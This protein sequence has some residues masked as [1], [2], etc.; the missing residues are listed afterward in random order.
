MEGKK[1]SS[2]SQFGAVWFRFRKNKLAL[3]GLVLLVIIIFLAI[4]ANLFIDEELVKAMS[5]ANAFQPP[6]AEHWFGTDNY[7]RDVFARVIYG[8]RV[9]LRV[10]IIAVF[11]AVTI[12]GLLGAA[13]GYFGGV[14]ENVIMR[15]MDIFLAIPSMMLAITVVAA[16]GTSLTNLMIALIIART[17]QFARIVRSAVL[18][19]R[20]Q[21]YIEAALACGTSHWRI[22][23]KHIIPNVVGPVI[24]QATLQMGSVIIN[25][26]GLSFIGLGIEPPTPEWGSMLSEARE[27]IRTS[28]YLVIPP[29]LAIMISVFSF[30][31]IG[32]GLRDALDPKLKN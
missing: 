15:V 3:V 5:V 10:G 25:I 4:F 26:A 6:S 18:P 21:E 22:I 2:R 24:V 11:G 8:G 16:L 27:F 31:R 12:G 14:V 32:D 20:G 7:G 23:T 19:L 29:G 9:S 17:P 30:N 13:A 28:P 1:T